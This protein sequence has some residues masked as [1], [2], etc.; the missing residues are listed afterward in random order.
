MTPARCGRLRSE[1]EKRYAEPFGEGLDVVAAD[2]AAVEEVELA[3]DVEVDA[4]GL[5]VGAT[6]LFL[7]HGN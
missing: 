6:S 5:Q 3:Q 4:L 7:K 2:R 1:W